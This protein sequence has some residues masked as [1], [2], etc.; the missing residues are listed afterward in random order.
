MI[1]SDAFEETVPAVS[2]TR[3]VCKD[4]PRNRG[5]VGRDLLC[6][7]GC[8]GVL[9]LLEKLK[10]MCSVRRDRG[11]AYRLGRFYVQQR[12]VLVGSGRGLGLW[13]QQGVGWRWGNPAGTR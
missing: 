4:E 1:G 10:S 12:R 6:F 3:A 8:R 5:I 9:L 11:I 2:G 13:T 7:L